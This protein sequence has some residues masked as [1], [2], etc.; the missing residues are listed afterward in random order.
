MAQ[1]FVPIYGEIFNKIPNSPGVVEAGDIYDK[2]QK[3]DE[4]QVPKTQSEI[5]AEVLGAIQDQSTENTQKVLLLNYQSRNRINLFQAL[6]LLFR[7][8]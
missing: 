3:K 2:G 4:T 1:E 8:M 5:N 6:I 7:E